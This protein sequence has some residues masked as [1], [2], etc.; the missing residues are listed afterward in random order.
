M[1]RFRFYSLVLMTLLG[2]GE[3]F[4]YDFEAGGLYYNITSTSDKT[5]EVTFET[6]AYD[7]YKGEITVP[8]SAV[9]D[10]VT[11]AVTKIGDNAFNSC[12]ELTSVS[13]AGSVTAIGASAF[14]DCGVLTTL[15]TET[16]IPPTCNDNALEGIDK[17]KCKLYVIPET[18]AAY[19]EAE[20]W[21]DFTMMEGL[22]VKDRKLRLQLMADSE[23]DVLFSAEPKIDF[24]DGDV[25]LSWADGSQKWVFSDVEA[26][27]FDK[28]YSTGTT[29]GIKSIAGNGPLT[30]SMTAD[31]GLSVV[32]GRGST[33][34][35]C[36]VNGETVLRKGVK[37]DDEEVSLEQ[38]P[39]GVYIINV[40]GKSVKVTKK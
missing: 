37:T 38:L 35:V 12:K 23:T 31:K 21:K 17:Q 25:Q 19:K 16:K 26:F 7:S 29:T 15:A 27:S 13:L 33:V 11:Y 22:T 1:K 8:E 20:Q 14:A 34:I 3:V 32:G 36:S 2:A 10:G 28:I 30:L 40:G 9:K 6:T 18:M 5:C 39:A 4:A 24:P